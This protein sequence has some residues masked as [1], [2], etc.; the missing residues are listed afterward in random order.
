MHHVRRWIGVKAKILA[1]ELVDPRPGQSIWVQPSVFARPVHSSAD[2]N[3]SYRSILQ[4]MLVD[5]ARIDV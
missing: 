1:G 5:R 4:P 2:R 3:I